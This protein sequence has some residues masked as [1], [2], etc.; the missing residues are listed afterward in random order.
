MGIALYSPTHIIWINNSGRMADRKVAIK[1]PFLTSPRCGPEL[2]NGI[3]NASLPMPP[4]VG[5]ISVHCP[6][7]STFYF[8]LFVVPAIMR[9]IFVILI[10]PKWLKQWNGL[11]CVIMTCFDFSSSAD[12][13]F[14]VFVLC[15]LYHHQS[16]C[17][18]SS[19]LSISSS[20]FR[21]RLRIA[22]AVWDEKKWGS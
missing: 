15:S 7:S 4:S 14:L 3:R 19:F 20:A 16:L 13:F 6:L 8:G 17:S 12:P 9:P 10:N 11:G 1:E 18:S 21:L 5:R 2:G 22:E